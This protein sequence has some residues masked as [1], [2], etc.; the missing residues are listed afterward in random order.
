MGWIK[1]SKN[2]PSA[3]LTMSLI[4]FIAVTVWLVTWLIA[5]PFGA[6]VPTFD[7]ATAMAYLTPVL[8]LYFGRRWTSDNGR[9]KAE[10]TGEK[11]DSEDS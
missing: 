5:T 3:S 1:N 2:E 9:V 8:T 11:Y 6:P 7:A 10:G 4:A